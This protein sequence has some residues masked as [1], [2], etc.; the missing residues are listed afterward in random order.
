MPCTLLWQR[1]AAIPL[2]LALLLVGLLTLVS[3]AA[4]AQSGNLFSN[5]GFEA[6]TLS[7][8]VIG[9]AGCGTP[10]LDSQQPHSGTYDGKIGSGF[11]LRPTVAQAVVLT[12]G[13]TY[14]LSAW[15]RG[16]SNQCK[17]GYSPASTLT[18]GTFGPATPVTTS[19]SQLSWSFLYTGATGSGYAGLWCDLQRGYQYYD[20]LALTSGQSLA[21]LL[22]HPAGQAGKLIDWAHPVRVHPMPAWHRSGL[23]TE[24]APGE[25]PLPLPSPQMSTSALGPLLVA[26]QA[27][28]PSTCY[29]NYAYYVGVQGRY[30]WSATFGHLEAS[31]AYMWCPQFAGDQAGINWAYGRS[32][33]LSGCDFVFNGQNTWGAWAGA[34]LIPLT[35][36][37]LFDG[38]SYTDY[39]ICAPGS[40][41]DDSLTANGSATYSVEMYSV[42]ASGDE[43]TAY[44]PFG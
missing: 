22:Q 2:I 25:V 13:A 3:A 36:N 21:A 9:G 33:I 35:G 34:D 5:P 39:D 11:C 41:W 20:D 17:L 32:Y 42:D 43:A 14:A 31:V 24:V 8:W 44:S 37:S 23:G 1:R 15:T 29:Q 10:T 16:G 27:N 40:A 19:W 26:P 18:N 38:E 6:G 28:F 30:S 12:Q 7:P 4:H